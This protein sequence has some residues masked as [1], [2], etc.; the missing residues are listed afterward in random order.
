M[1]PRR[2]TQA[3]YLNNCYF[4]PTFT[5]SPIVTGPYYNLPPSD[6][7][8][9]VS[10]EMCPSP[11][12]RLFE[13][14]NAWREQFRGARPGSWGEGVMGSWARRPDVEYQ[15]YLGGGVGILPYNIF[16][17]YQYARFGNCTSQHYCI[18]KVRTRDYT[19]PTVILPA[20]NI[21]LI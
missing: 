17:G 20:I 2:A 18:A 14:V 15:C 19:P 9:P 7:Y 6:L 4:A 10:P 8:P 16:P 11:V 5:S 13:S 3:S 12:T 1:S 21:L